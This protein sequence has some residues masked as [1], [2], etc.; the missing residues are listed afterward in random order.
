MNPWRSQFF[1]RLNNRR[2]DAQRLWLCLLANAQAAQCLTAGL[3]SIGRPAML[4]QLLQSGAPSLLPFIA[5]YCFCLGRHAEANVAFY[6]LLPSLLPLFLLQPLP[7]LAKIV[8]FQ[9]HCLNW[10][11]RL[12]LAPCGKGHTCTNSHCYEPRTSAN[13]A[14]MCQI[15]H[16]VESWWALAR[17]CSKNIVQ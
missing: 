2:F 15:H 3:W 6:C 17:T 16:D 11:H 5:F 14:E 7:C 4:R 10:S 12:L 9:H 8:K 13:V 1:S